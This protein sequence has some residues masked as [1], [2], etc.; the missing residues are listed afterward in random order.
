MEDKIIMEFVKEVSSK[1][2]KHIKSIILFG[3][4][5]KNTYKPYSD[6]DFLIVLDQRKHNII[7]KI[8]DEVVNFLL[9][10]EVDI[11]L[12]IYSKRDY[13]EKFSLGTPFMEEIKKHGKVIW[14]QK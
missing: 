11:S 9:N 3:S 6:Y 10:Y 5:V 2:G 13:L 8:Y 12:K 4:R 1:T 7:N 14:N